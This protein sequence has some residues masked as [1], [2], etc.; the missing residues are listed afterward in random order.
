MDFILE[1]E[2]TIRL[3]V[4]AGLFLLMAV[5]ETIRP[6]R[7][8]RFKRP[9]RWFSNLGILFL[10]ALIA[11]LILPWAPV[12]VALY[13]EQNS[14]GLFHHFELIG[15]A[16]I[17]L[18][19]IMLDFM[20][21]VQ[22]VLMHKVPVLWRLHR[23]HHADLDYDVTTGIRFHPI[24]IILS[25][26]YKMGIILITGIDPVAVVLFEVILNGM[27]MFNHANFRLPL[28]LDRVLRLIFVT[29]DMHRVHHSSIQSET[30]SNYGFN[31]SLWDRFFHTYVA[32][33]Q[34][35]H[36]N[37]TIGLEYFRDPSDLRLDRLLIQPF[38]GTTK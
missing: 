34:N 33:P 38:K 29:P 35:G 32:Q 19:I 25:L 12:G 21:Y 13:A 11:R 20:I 31:I 6:R 26:L 5:L 18:G 16:F 2:S 24:E 15:P 28:G 27:A 8:Q 9:K 36:E 23:L 4:F 22:H 3:S 17:A 10:G 7:I 37:M 30:D 1:N 14:I